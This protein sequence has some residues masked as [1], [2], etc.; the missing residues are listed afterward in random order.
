[1]LPAQAVVGAAA[2]TWP[3]AGRCRRNTA[4][5]D[6][7]S[8]KRQLSMFDVPCVDLRLLA[9]DEDSESMCRGSTQGAAKQPFSIMARRDP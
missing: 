9:N 4:D 8:K 5:V 2:I 1:M 7:P 6:E 3:W